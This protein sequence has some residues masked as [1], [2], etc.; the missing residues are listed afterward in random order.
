MGYVSDLGIAWSDLGDLGAVWV[1]HLGDQGWS[2]CYIY[3]LIQGGLAVGE[4]RPKK[5]GLLLGYSRYPGYCLVTRHTR[6]I[7]LATP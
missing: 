7:A 3:R 1:V 2:G 6:Q 5:S 4:P